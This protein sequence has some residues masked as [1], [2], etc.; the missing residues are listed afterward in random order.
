MRDEYGRVVIAEIAERAL[1]IR[2]RELRGPFLEAV[3][4]IALRDEQVDREAL[5]EQADQMFESFADRAAVARQR[6]AV[7]VEQARRVERDDDAVDP[8][9]RTRAAELVQHRAPRALVGVGR[10]GIGETA[11][12]I[13]HDRVVEAP[14][15]AVLGRFDVRGVIRAPQRRREARAGQRGRL[16]RAGA[17]EHEVPRQRVQRPAAQ[18]RRRRG[19]REGRD[20]GAPAR[21]QPGFRRVAAGQP[22]GRVE[23]RQ[24]PARTGGAQ[25]APRVAAQE[26]AA[27]PRAEQGDGEPLR[28]VEIKRD[29]PTEECEREQRDDSEEQHT[30]GFHRSFE[31]VESTMCRMT[32]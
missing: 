10:A 22:F 15:V 18:P 20:R 19:A 5:L 26:P 13:E 9:A 32:T 1:S 24:L 30:D 2:R 25:R 21:G 16:A 17:A 8:A 3:E 23:P 12:E 28:P 6:V 29:G 4:A 7:R 27:E 14:P 11:G 31:R